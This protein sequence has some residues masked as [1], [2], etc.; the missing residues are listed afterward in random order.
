M[1]GLPADSSIG[2][3]ED[4]SRF[5]AVITEG[6]R[7]FFLVRQSTGFALLSNVCPHQGG[8]VYDK[9]TCFECPLHGWQF[10]LSTGRCLTADDRH[11]RVRPA[12]QGEPPAPAAEPDPPGDPAA[13]AAS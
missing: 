5:P 4:F 9:G 7:S 13:R 10:D 11:L 1:L 6:L 8:A 12:C 3:P 2:R